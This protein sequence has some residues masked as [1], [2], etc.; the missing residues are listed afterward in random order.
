[1]YAR[2]PRANPAIL[3]ASHHTA[4][5]AGGPV[6]RGGTPGAELALYFGAD[7]FAALADG[8]LD[9]E[10]ALARRAVGYAG[11]LRLLE[12]L[13][14]LLQGGGSAHGVRSTP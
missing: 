5:A 11:D 14:R 7:A 1:M 9:I 8:T 12:Q 4:Q 3:A 2:L 6:T 10:R 13:G